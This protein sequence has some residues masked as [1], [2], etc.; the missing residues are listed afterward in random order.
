MLNAL[1]ALG[2]DYLVRIKADA[3]FHPRKGLCRRLST[4]IQP[5]GSF[6]ARGHLFSTCPPMSRC[7]AIWDS[8]QKQA[9][10]LFTNVR[11]LSGRAYAMRWWQE[12]SFKDLK[13][14]G[15]QLQQTKLRRSARRLHRHLFVMALAYAWMISLG[16]NVVTAPISI[17]RRVATLDDLRRYSIFRLGL[18]W[19]NYLIEICPPK[20]RFQLIFKRAVLQLRR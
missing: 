5:G 17:Q 18:R 11:W 4:L 19:F 16:T 14:G 7:F 12:E 20:L 6:S 9:W 2:V 3:K 1:N 8:D 10:C 13:S 15:W